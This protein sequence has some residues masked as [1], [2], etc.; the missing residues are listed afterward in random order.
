M[1]AEVEEAAA[2]GEK[3]KK[4]APKQDSLGNKIWREVLS[5]FWVIVA[6]LLIEGTLV[7]ARVIPSGSMERTVLIGDHLI[8]SRIGYDAGIPFTDY[9]VPLWRD[10]KRQQI[11]VFRAPLPGNPDFIKR[12]IG[13]P[14]DTIEIKHGVVYI[15]G[16]PLSEP[17]REEEPNPSEF[18]ATI[19]VPPG[20]YFMMG[21]NRENSYDSR[22]WGFVPRENIIGAPLM[23]YM[24]IDAPE[25][26]W[27]PGHVG[28]R[29]A[30]Y[31]NAV[32]HPREVRWNRLFHTF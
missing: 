7:Q 6:F 26:V 19:H 18:R 21:D 32:I 5:W 11:I 3:E 15:N 16:N 10:P 13:L 25:Q 8:V 14:G 12:V 20:K 30:T 22:Y 2:A 4:S 31:I 17:Y 23:I 24:S 28:E 29:F 1:K 9:H 27:E